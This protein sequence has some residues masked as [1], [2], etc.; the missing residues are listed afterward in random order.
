MHMTIS[1]F[2]KSVLGANLLN[3]RWSWGAFSPNTNRLFLRVWEHGLA[4]V[5]G[6]ECISIMDGSWERTSAGFNER[7]RHVDMLRNGA[8]G[9]GILCVAK[10]PNGNGTRTIERFD[11]TTLLKFGS[12]IDDDEHVYAQIID[13]IRVED[14][15]QART[16]NGALAPDII[17]ILKRR[18]EITTKESLI[19]ARVG[20]GAFR[21]QILSDWDFKCC[22]TGSITL[23]A[24]RAS[25]IKPWR[26]ST[27]SERLDPSNGLPLVATLDALF[28]AGLISF[29]SEG[30]LLVSDRLDV[31]EKALLGLAGLR[32]TRKPNDRTVQ[33][34]TYHREKIFI[35]RLDIRD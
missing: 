18:S 10:D 35:D 2:F 12:I 31:S 20:Q 32:L 22:V 1:Q 25:H 15:A 29:G 28:D 8:S 26:N 6:I 27:D 14:L 21:A 11:S 24:I 17:S 16:G 19:N 34:L 13:R 33:F 3:S 30:E 9:Y 7:K 5:D 4:S 23:D